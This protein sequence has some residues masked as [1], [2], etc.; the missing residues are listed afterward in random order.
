MPRKKNSFC[1]VSTFFD[2]VREGKAK[3]TAVTI[4]ESEAHPPNGEAGKIIW[5]VFFA[6]PM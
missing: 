1:P 2:L 6:L 5:L 4:I 3:K